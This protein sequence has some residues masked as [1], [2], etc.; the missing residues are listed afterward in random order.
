VRDSLYNQSLARVAL[1]SAAR[2]NAV[3]NGTTVDTGIFGNDFRTVLFV[4]QTG[5]IT[6]GSHAV[7]LQDSADGSTGW[8]AVDSGT[9][10]GA[11]PTIVATDDDTVLQFGHSV[12]RQYLRLVVTTTGATT[13]GIFAAVAVMSDASSDPVARS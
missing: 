7:T 11:L 2:T 1:P 12:V 13:G 5:V 9:I 10:Q 8:T 3:V 6:D 4:I